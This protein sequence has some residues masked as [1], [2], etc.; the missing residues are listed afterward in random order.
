M[1]FY[2][3]PVFF[4]KN[5]KNISYNLLT[6]DFFK[7]KLSVKTPIIGLNFS[8]VDLYE[9]QLYKIFRSVNPILLHQLIP[10]C[11]F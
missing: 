2:K 4:K 1:L 10:R 8:N 9:K 6:S 7:T 5:K 11:G 3:N